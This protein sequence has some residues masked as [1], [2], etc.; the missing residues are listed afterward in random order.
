MLFGDRLKLLRLRAAL[1]QPELARRA[2]VGLPSI[3]DWE[4]GRRS[5][6]LEIAI[7]LAAALNVSIV[8]FSDCQFVT[9]YG[10]KPAAGGGKSKRKAK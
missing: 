6:S 10:A 7:R 3:K 5:P 9:G 2:G 1:T 8:A 4:A